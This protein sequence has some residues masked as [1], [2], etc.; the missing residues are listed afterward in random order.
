MLADRPVALRAGEHVNEEW[1]DFVTDL[2][3]RFRLALISAAS[4]HLVWLHKHST[5]TAGCL[6]ANWRRTDGA[7]SDITG[8]WAYFYTLTP[9]MTERKGSI[10]KSESETKYTLRV[11]KEKCLWWLGLVNPLFISFILRKQPERGGSVWDFWILTLC[12]VFVGPGEPR[13]QQQVQKVD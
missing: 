9:V 12:W 1:R 4:L 13:Q 3:T 7:P 10:W 5:E 11:L 2:S 8:A 6:S